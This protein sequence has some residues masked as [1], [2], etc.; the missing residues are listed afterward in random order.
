MDYRILGPLEVADRDRPIHVGAGRQRTVLALLLIH[1][2]EVVSSERLID[3][4]WGER[5][6]PTAAKMLHN[7]IFEL[8]RAL[9]AAESGNGTAYGRL[10]TRGHGYLLSV[11]PGELDLDRVEAGLEA[12]RRALA[13]GDAERAAAKFGAVLALW[14]GPALSELADTTDARAQIR[15]V[16]ERRLLALEGRFE[17]ELTLGRDAELVGEIEAAVAREPLRE[18]L[19]AQLMLALYRSGRQVEALEAYRDGRRVLAE[20]LGLEPGP[21]LTRLERAILEHDQALE[22][23]PAPIPAPRRAARDRR[24]Q[25][26][27]AAG[28]VLFLAAAGAVVLQV[29]SGGNFQAGLATAAPNS[30]AAIDAVSGRI[31]SQTP[32][33]ENPGGIAAGSEAIWVLNGDDRTVSRID[34]TTRRVTRTFAVG[35]VPTALA[36]GGGAVW[37]GAGSIP[38]DPRVTVG[39]GNQTAR[40]VV[41]IG[42]ASGL[43]DAHVTLPRRAHAKAYAAL[44]RGQLAVGDGAVWAVT[45]DGG[46]ARIDPATNRARARTR[47]VDASSLAVGGGSVWALGAPRL[48]TTIWQIDAR[49][50]KVI[51]RIDVPADLLN[52]IAF[53]AGAL[54]ATDPV[55]GKVWRIDIGQSGRRP[56]MQTIASAPGV[57][58]IAFEPR[59][60][61]VTNPLDDTISRIDPAA[62]RVNRVIQMQAAPRDIAVGH[63]SVWVTLAGAGSGAAPASSVRSGGLAGVRGASCRPVVFAG[64]RAPDAL[65]VSDLALQGAARGDALSMS[66]AVALTLKRHEFRAGRLTVGYQ[67]CDDATAEANGPD[68]VRCRRNARAYAAD[69]RVAGVIGP[70]ESFCG[71]LQVG[72]ANRA[73]G[74]PL[75]MVSASA[76]APGFTRAG[77][78][79]ESGEPA[80]Y[81]AS[82]Q[83]SFARVIPADDTH[84]AVAAVLAR[85]L[86]LRRIFIVDD[87][88]PYGGAVADVFDRAAHRLRVGLVGRATWDGGRPAARLIRRIAQT[89]PDGVF[90]SVQAF[91]ANGGRLVRALRRTLGR[92]VVLIGTDGL[93]PVGL[94]RN[95]AGRAADGLYLTTYLIPAAQLNRRGREFVREFQRTQPDGSSPYWALYAAQATEVLLA[96][97]ARSDGTRSSISRALF[98][99]GLTDA[100]LGPAAIDQNGDITPASVP[101]YR[102][103]RRASRRDPL[104]P[105]DLEGASLDRIVTPSPDLLRYALSNHH[106]G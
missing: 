89:R 77:T 86:G 44:G 59:G 34:P 88:Q 73:R 60:V 64:A 7:Y 66:H 70:F 31:V 76:T 51:R 33:G 9:A 92:R 54:W 63:G 80:K 25:V 67:A 65:L 100:P 37:I 78:M 29:G 103:D 19:R 43:T 38:S 32:V 104:L 57:S 50:G 47:T 101:V 99:T 23:P 62:N 17:A 82:G 4:L 71:S 83:R 96:A 35:A 20:Q 81:F 22:P 8:R 74:G 14:R 11:K 87:R 106:A 18:R 68:G 41:R 94:L 93:K 72:V 42:G 45:P 39:P 75:A 5:P 21:A 105:P 6:P 3:E 102:I 13:E 10:M 26:L 24:W 48:A 12:G 84:G 56:V 28:A 30:V 16:E 27:L 40:A 46:V 91:D 79:T 53:G 49:S 98:A 69:P 55:A 15:R 2:N 61:W 97:I 95:G 90:I 1:R 36:A 58:A 52:A 85:D